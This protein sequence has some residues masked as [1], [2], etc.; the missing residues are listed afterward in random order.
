MSPQAARGLIIQMKI[1]YLMFKLKNYFSLLTS[2]YSDIAPLLLST[3]VCIHRKFSL[4]IRIRNQ[5]DG[6]ISIGKKKCGFHKLAI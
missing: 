4:P 5:M 3:V 6:I 1:P 2:S